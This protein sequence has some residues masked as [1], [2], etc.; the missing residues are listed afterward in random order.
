MCIFA[1]VLLGARAYGGPDCILDC[2]CDLGS[3]PLLL[4]LHMYAKGAVPAQA[5]DAAVF[6]GALR[7]AMQ[8][9]ERKHC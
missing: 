5:S 9:S 8:E 7:S 3:Q 4:W 2:I 6:C 1:G